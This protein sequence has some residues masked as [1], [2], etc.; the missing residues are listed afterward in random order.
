MIKFITIVVLLLGCFNSSDGQSRNSWP[1]FRGNQQLNGVSESELP[2]PMK[3]LWTFHTGDNIKSAPV[4]DRQRVVVGSTDGHVYCLDL[5]G[6]LLWKFNTGN[7]IEAPALIHENTV[8]IGNMDGILYAFD[9]DTGKERWKYETENQIIGSANWWNSGKTT[10]IL[11]GSYD[12][13]LH[14]VDAGSGKGVWKYESDNFINGAAACYEGKAFFGGCDGFLHIVDIVTGKIEK[15]IDVATYVPGSPA[16]EKDKAYLGDYD[17]R[18]FQV[19]IDKDITVWEWKDENTTLPFIASPAMKGNRIITANH[20]KFIYCFDKYTGR[21]LWKYNSANRVEA[22]PVIAGDKVIV[23]NMRGD[24]ILL[25]EADGEELWK[26]E[27]G[28]QIIN[29]PAVAGGR[30]Y[31][32]A[33]DGVV[34]CFGK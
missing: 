20:N 4:V 28:S 33:F 21:V 13:N 29:N 16:V 30:I 15:K 26:Y 8:Y 18:F 22:S 3:L 25:N 17:G 32:G 11:V 31:A 5:N 12:Y 1:L 7:A 14:C 19:N 6:D 27:I 24:L 34:Y 23:A 2:I 9:L 10:Y